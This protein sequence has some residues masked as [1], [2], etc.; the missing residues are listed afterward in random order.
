MK[1]G[2]QTYTI[3]TFTQNER[4]FRESMKRL[5]GMGYKYVQLSGV[6]PQLSAGFMRA[7]CDE[8]ELKIV[9][10]HSKLDIV[11]DVDSVIRFHETLGCR[12]IGIG[13]C[14]EKYRSP[15]WIGRFA[16]DY[17]GPAKE[18]K[19]AGFR[20]MYHTHSD[21]WARLPDGELIIDR[22]TRDMPAD[23]MGITLDLYSLHATGC[24][25]FQ[26]IG[27]LHDRLQCVHL[28]DMA[29]LVNRPVMAPI[30][31]GNMDYEGILALLK[32]LGDTE[33]A[34]VEQ[35]DCNGRDPFECL[36]SSYE[37]LKR[38]DVWG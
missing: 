15:G 20:F 29:V 28:K 33:Y 3:R 30:G 34:L 36:R 2:A 22:L 14:G 10:T 37:F 13:G 24:N 16:E 17:A 26:W 27:R 35:D 5:H 6:G 32:K 12:Y 7:V 23:L 9:L 18:M 4:D 31:E 19:D 1:F 11:N 21:E 25:V 38:Q 8:Y